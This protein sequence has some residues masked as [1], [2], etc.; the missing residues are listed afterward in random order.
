MIDLRHCLV[1]LCLAALPLQARLPA[2]RL[3]EWQALSPVAREKAREEMQAWQ[4][5]PEA[6]RA[7]LRQAAAAFARLPAA[8]QASLRARFAAL[9]L[10]EQR[11]WRL[12]PQLG[13]WYPQLQPLFAYVGEAE[14]E[15]LLRMLHQMSQ[16]EL[17]TLARL[18]FS[19]PPEGRAALRAE[20][21]RQ[22]PSGRLVWML[23]QLD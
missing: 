21:L 4:R 10:D 22:H 17:E 16:E 18:S 19:T 14:R 11:G 5:L 3:S 7:Q 13:L 23:Q 8:Q 15:P 6:Q 9:P 20:L 12:G 2:Q 1:A